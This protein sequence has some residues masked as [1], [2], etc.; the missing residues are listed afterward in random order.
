MD[1]GPDDTTVKDVEKGVFED[2]EKGV[3][4]DIS[5][6]GVLDVVGVIMVDVSPA[7]EVSDREDDGRFKDSV[8]VVVTVEASDILGGTDGVELKNQ[9]EDQLEDQLRVG[10]I[11][12]VVVVGNP[13]SQLYED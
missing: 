5:S 6:G 4:E 3:F 9:L 1:D 13:E 7:V 2:V 12:G 10:E 11:D 8:V